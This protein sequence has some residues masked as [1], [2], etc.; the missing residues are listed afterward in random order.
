[1]IHFVVTIWHTSLVIPG[2]QGSSNK[3]EEQNND[4]D[5]IPDKGFELNTVHDL[6][7][8]LFYL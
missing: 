4:Q 7:L 8:T 3:H 2:T 1:M 5:E 6:E